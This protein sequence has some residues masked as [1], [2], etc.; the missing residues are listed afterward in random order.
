MTDYNLSSCQSKEALWSLRV[1]KFSHKMRQHAACINVCRSIAILYQTYL[2]DCPINSV[3][4]FLPPTAPP[5]RMVLGRH[6]AQYFK[7]PA[8]I[9]NSQVDRAILWLYLKGSRLQPSDSMGHIHIYQVVRGETPLVTSSVSV[10]L[11]LALAIFTLIAYH[12]C[13]ALYRFENEPF[14]AV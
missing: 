2:S 13:F 9:V 8:N 5:D 7:F 1:A 11:L 4:L 12:L 10:V 3:S 6:R 14:Q